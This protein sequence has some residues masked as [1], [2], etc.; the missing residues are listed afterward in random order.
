M[1]S[2]RKKS[3]ARY[4]ACVGLHYPAPAGGEHRV[5]AGAIISDLPTASISW[6]LEQQLIEQV[7]NDDE[8]E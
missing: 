8:E 7:P 2:Q 3:R 4:R 6:L 1:T 5:E